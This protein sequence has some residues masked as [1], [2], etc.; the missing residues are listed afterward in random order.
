MSKYQVLS[1]PST[2]KYGPEKTPYLDAFQAVHA[3]LVL[4]IF[5][6]SRKST[7]ISQSME[8]YISF[9]DE[10][11]YLLTPRK[12]LVKDD[13]KVNFCGMDFSEQRVSKL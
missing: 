10:V 7:E 9:S 11:V 13:T 8:G 3:A 5:Q 2:R 6:L 4:K 12:L 1:I